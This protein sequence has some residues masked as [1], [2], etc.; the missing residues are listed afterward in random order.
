LFA[1]GLGFI[2]FAYETVTQ[3]SFAFKV[4]H[5]QN[6]ANPW[7]WKWWV[8]NGLAGLFSLALSIW[9]LSRFVAQVRK[10]CPPS[11]PIA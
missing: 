4:F 6:I 8:G 9:C 11:E 1:T 7:W 10:G 5:S 2:F 3:E